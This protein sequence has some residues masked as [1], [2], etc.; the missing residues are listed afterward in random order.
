[1]A[2]ARR[3]ALGRH[4]D[5]VVEL[6]VVSPPRRIRTRS[7]LVVVR[8]VFAPLALVS[9]AGLSA[10]AMILPQ[11][12]AGLEHTDPSMAAASPLGVSRDY[13]RPS[14]T[15]AA[16][17]APSASP[18]VSAT[19]S[20]SPTPS[21]TPSPS[22]AP[23]TSAS[24]AP[25]VA[26]PAAAPSKT[27]D[28]SALGDSAGTRY[29]SASVNLRTGPGVGYDAR[30]TLGEGTEVA[31]TQWHVDGWRQ[32]EVSH[33]AGWIKE[34]F[35]TQEKPVVAPAPARTSQAADSGGSSSSG[36]STEACAAASGIESGLTARTRSVLRA[37]CAE[38]PRVTSYGGYRAD[39]D[40][41]HASG[42]A[43]DVMVSGEAGWE[44]A[45]WARANATALG[46][47]EVL[48]SQQIWTAQ[49]S[50]DGWRSFSDRGSV[51]ANHYDHVHISVR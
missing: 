37:V 49:R 15:P 40:S 47:I 28:Y 39:S 51:S 14:L 26:T 45:R 9:V 43:I 4:D 31:I 8:F 27:V 20:P 25:A 13:L 36:F 16:S 24:A 5:E 1:M 34:G 3:T 41:Y 21:A 30:T 46:I 32:V 35:L 19:P 42:R 33:K 11:T 7:P 38:F 29:T 23:S 50:G 2:Q 22:A 44:I 48:Y 12:G 17:A 6:G 10:L 18:S